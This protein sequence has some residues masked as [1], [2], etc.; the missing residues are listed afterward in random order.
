MCV[1][2]NRG[3]GGADGGGVMAVAPNKGLGGALGGGVMVVAPS[4]GVGGALG[5]EV[6]GGSE[7]FCAASNRCFWAANSSG[8][9]S[10]SSR[11]AFSS[12]SWSVRDWG[13]G[14]WPSLY[15]ND[16]SVESHL[17]RL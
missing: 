8:V 6:S 17:V 4:S 11:S 3:L 7:L 13:I 12:R 15:P 2:P 14:L 16:A 9:S 1:A 10:P 5:G